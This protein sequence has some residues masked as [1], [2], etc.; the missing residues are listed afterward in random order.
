MD[1]EQRAWMGAKG[2]DPCHKGANSRRHK[3]QAQRRVCADL[4]PYSESWIWA[5]VPPDS[6]ELG[7]SESHRGSQSQSIEPGVLDMG[8]TWRSDWK[9]P[10]R[11]GHPTERQLVLCVL[12]IEH[13][14]GS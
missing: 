5:F 9:V 4:H 7:I 1:N 12:F 3:P 10:L 14:V 2:V 6:K 11:I 8:A 13:L